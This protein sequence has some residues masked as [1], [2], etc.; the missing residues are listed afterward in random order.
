MF[1]VILT[2]WISGHGDSRQIVFIDIGT[3]EIYLLSETEIL[4]DSTDVHDLLASFTGCHVFGFRSRKRDGI[5]SAG[6]P[7]D[8]ASVKH[9]DKTGMGSACIGVTGPVRVNSDPEDIA[10]GNSLLSEYE[11]LF[12]SYC[13]QVFG[14]PSSLMHLLGKD[15]S[16]RTSQSL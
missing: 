2:D 4:K 6:L 8:L 9:E 13:R 16:V 15:R 1:E 14:P 10:K 5:L 7:A 3:P 12:G 11:K